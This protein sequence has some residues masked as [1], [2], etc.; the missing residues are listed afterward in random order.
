MSTTKPS[1]TTT[2]NSFTVFKPFVLKSGEVFINKRKEYNHLF[3]LISGKAI[4]SNLETIG[5]IVKA[6]DFFFIPVS[7]EMLCEAVSPCNAVIFSYSEYANIYEQIY[8]RGL[9]NLC[10]TM[11]DHFRI[12]QMNSFIYWFM[13]SLK[14]YFQ[15]E[16]DKTEIQKVKHEEFFCLLTASYTK[17]QL[18]SFFYPV[19]GKS[20]EFRKFIFD[21]YLKVKNIEELIQLQG[22]TRK[23]FDR[24]FTDEFGVPA[25]QWILNQ[26]AKHIRFA[27]AE[28][29][30]KMSDI[31][32]RYGFV[33]APHFTRFC[34]EQFNHSPLKLRKYLQ[35]RR[36]N[37]LEYCKSTLE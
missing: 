22:I 19:I 30:D 37:A 3:F 1:K 9:C 31:M 21:N 18:A 34:K 24:Q 12:M 6:G 14:D 10:A 20:F 23:T 15:Y 35:E 2:T 17:K 36:L 26:K 11:G 32:N 28:T 7:S 4:V 13:D 27:L 29:Q 16:L 33:I 8:F 5:N 25:Y